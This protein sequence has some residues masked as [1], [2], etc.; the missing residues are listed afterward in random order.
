[1]RDSRLTPLVINGLLSVRQRALE[2]QPFYYST[3]IVFNA[4]HSDEEITLMIA[5]IL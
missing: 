4:V 2:H 1:M 5:Y 3:I